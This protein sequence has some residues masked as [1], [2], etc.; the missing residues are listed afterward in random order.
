[1]EPIDLSS[2]ARHSLIYSTLKR[3]CSAGSDGGVNERIWIPLVSRLITRGLESG[4]M[5]GGVTEGESEEETAERRKRGERLREVL[6]SYVT[7]DLQ[8]R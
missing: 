2:S 4:V 7:K 8:A 3:I 1:M 6:F 5:L